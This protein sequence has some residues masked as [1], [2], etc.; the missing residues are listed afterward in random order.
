LKSGEKDLLR[1]ICGRRSW[2][3]YPRILIRRDIRMV[4]KKDSIPLGDRKDHITADVDSEWW[5]LIIASL[6]WGSW[7][8][9][10]VIIVVL[11]LVF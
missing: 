7:K 8:L 1:C 10:F 3:S 11:I 2:W 6:M 4:D 5:V 9:I